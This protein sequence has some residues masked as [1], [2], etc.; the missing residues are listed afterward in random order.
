M[1][2]IL[3]RSVPENLHTQFK[4]WCAHSKVTQQEV[5]TTMLRE[6][7]HEPYGTVNGKSLIVKSR[8]DLEELG[9][10]DRK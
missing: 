1:K 9:K 4:V 10:G 3:I 7:I 8:I 2:N 6:Q 5:L